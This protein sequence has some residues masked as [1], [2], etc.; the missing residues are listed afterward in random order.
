MQEFDY[1]I[2]G[3]GA[4]GLMLAYRI[5]K[6][7]FFDHKSILIIDKEKKSTKLDVDLLMTEHGVI[8]KTEKEN[9]MM[10]YINLGTIFFLKV[11]PIKKKYP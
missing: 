4:S 1:I 11:I 8:G 6:D 3:T 2:T 10:F 5:A 9:G 7:P